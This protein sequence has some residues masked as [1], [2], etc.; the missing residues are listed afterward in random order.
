MTLVIPGGQRPLSLSVYQKKKSGGKK[1]TTNIVFSPNEPTCLFQVSYVVQQDIYHLGLKHLPLGHSVCSEISQK[2]HF[3]FFP[4]M[5]DCFKHQFQFAPLQP[6][7]VSG[8]VGYYWTYTSWRFLTEW[9][10]PIDSSWLYFL[11]HISTNVLCV[12]TLFHKI[13]IQ[14]FLKS[15]C[16]VALNLF[17]KGMVK[18]KS[19]LSLLTQYPMYKER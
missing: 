11:G 12:L 16:C 1:H 17:F 13:Q 18:P 2:V 6:P 3:H 14:S 19:W 7:G 10:L 5:R 8:N 4:C 9:F 15:S